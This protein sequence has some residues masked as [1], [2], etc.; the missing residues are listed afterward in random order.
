MLLSSGEDTGG[1]DDKSVWQYGKQSI[2]SVTLFFLNQHNS[3]VY[4]INS[5]TSVPP[6]VI[7]STSRA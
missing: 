2:E 3:T 6:N 1:P 4:F 5:P 7:E